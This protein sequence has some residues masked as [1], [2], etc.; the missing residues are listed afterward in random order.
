MT[1]KFRPRSLAVACAT[2]VAA[3]AAFAGEVEVLHW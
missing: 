2:L 1:T 3:G